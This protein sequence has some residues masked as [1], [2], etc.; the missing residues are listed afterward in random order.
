MAKTNDGSYKPSVLADIIS[1]IALIMVV[2]G[3]FALIMDGGF[4]I[5][6]LPITLVIS[7]GGICLIWF[8]NYLRY[9]H[10]FRFYRQNG[11]EEQFKTDVEL[12]FKI[13]NA[14]PCKRVLRYIMKLNPEAGKSIAQ[15]L[16]TA[17]R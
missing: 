2:G 12:C 14:N 11:Y 15:Q 10:L 7:G 6:N 17:K 8:S 1:K 13:Y 16:P 9:A 5:K 4:N 3:T